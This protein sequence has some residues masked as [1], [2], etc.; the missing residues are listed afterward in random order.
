MKNTQVYLL[1]LAIGMCSVS[2][3]QYVDSSPSAA[4]GQIF[5]VLV[6]TT[7]RCALNIIPLSL[8][9]LATDVSAYMVNVHVVLFFACS[10]VT[11]VMQ[12]M[13]LDDNKI[14]MSQMYS[15]P[16][17][18]LNS[19]LVATTI[20]FQFIIL[21]VYFLRQGSKTTQCIMGSTETA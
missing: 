6:A 4:P 20:I 15:T 21:P 14:D 7:Q 11:S 8:F 9:A 10:A 2:F 5:N 1:A 13:F 16:P 18:G 3:P 12:A 17:A 19:T